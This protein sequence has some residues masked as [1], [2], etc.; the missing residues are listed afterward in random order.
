MAPPVLNA[1]IYENLFSIRIILLLIPAYK[2]PPE[3]CK[4][5]VN[6]TL[7]YLIFNLLLSFMKI[8]P[9]Y[10]FSV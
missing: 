2:N 9:P 4:H 8:V 5:Q 3:L 10:K 1:Y 7:D 6:F